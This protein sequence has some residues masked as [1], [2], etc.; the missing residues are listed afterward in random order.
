MSINKKPYT[1]RM[2]LDILD[3][4]KA[5]TNAQELPVTV[6][7]VIERALTEFLDKKE[8]DNDQR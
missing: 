8:A 6:T 1:M 2:D 4:V 3:R 7:W 5:W